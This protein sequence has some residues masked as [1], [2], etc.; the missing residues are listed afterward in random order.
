M[1]RYDYIFIGS[2]ST[3]HLVKELLKESCSI[4]LIEY[5]EFV[6]TCLNRG[7]IPSKM[8]IHTAKLLNSCKEA[9]KYH[10]HTGKVTCDYEKVVQSVQKKI[11]DHALE[12]EKEYK[13]YPIDIYKDK[14]FFVGSKEIQV[15]TE[16]I[17]GDK[18]IVDVGAKPMIP[19]IFGLDSV[20]YITS[21]EAL[22]LEKLPKRL[23]IIGA[24]YIGV[25]MGYFFSSMGAK[26][27]IIEESSLLNLLDLDMQ[28]EFK[29][30]FLQYVDVIEN[31]K[32]HS[33]F[34]KD[35]KI[36]LKYN[37]TSIESDQLLV[38]T[39]RIPA[40]DDLCL[41]K[42]K[43][44]LDERGY[45]QV[46][47]YLETSEKDIYALGDCIHPLQLKHLANYEQK[48]LEKALINNKKEKIERP[49]IPAAV[50]AYPEVAIVGKTEK[51]LKN[52]NVEYFVKK[53]FY[54]DSGK[55]WLLNQ[56]I[57]LVKLIF[58]KSSNTLIGAS[59]VGEDA[60]ELIHILSLS[61]IQKITIDELE[62]SVFAHPS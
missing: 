22:K 50:F 41:D 60:A 42:T 27:T 48:Y 53:S 30:G 12:V 10:I 1:K 55:G 37:S 57:G 3:L 34:Q 25:E 6:G 52:S 54:K 45:I 24:G 43:I 19:K 36:I 2:G 39:G 9:S 61:I 16:V 23:T 44:Q 51:S 15:G 4:A 14:A 7:C 46:D 11:H 8:L 13:N 56:K 29:K 28:N 62:N 17:S 38:C 33:V 32:I 59:I 31:A 20:S 49:P 18:I 47:N 26:V 58:T 21:N 40:T 35:Q 5:Q